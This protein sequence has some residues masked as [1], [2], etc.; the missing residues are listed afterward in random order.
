MWEVTLKYIL[1]ESKLALYIASNVRG[2]RV[3]V[4]LT[5]KQLPK[6]WIFFLFK[7]SVAASKAQLI[8]YHKMC[9]SSVRLIMAY[10]CVSGRL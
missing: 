7:G 9:G 4:S 2:E 3:V 8:T 1:E 6:N 5:I 10:L